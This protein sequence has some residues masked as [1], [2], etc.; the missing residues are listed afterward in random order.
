MLHE[1]STPSNVQHC[2]TSAFVKPRI[3]LTICMCTGSSR[4]P[5]LARTPE[6]SIPNPKGSR[7]L[8]RRRLHSLSEA[9][10]P[11]AIVKHS[12]VGTQ[13]DV[14][15]DPQ[16]ADGNVQAHEAADALRSALR[17]NLQQQSMYTAVRVR[18]CSKLVACD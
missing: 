18:T 10:T 1:R 3:I 11:V 2:P 6:R 16:G 4:S 15:Q 9:H 14:T 17:V 13:E 12:V 5:Q 8:K 7:C